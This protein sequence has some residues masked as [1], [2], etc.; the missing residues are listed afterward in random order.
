MASLP[1]GISP[2]PT[3]GTGPSANGNKGADDIGRQ[4]EALKKELRQVKQ[5][6]TL[7]E[8]KRKKQIEALEKQIRELEQRRMQE[9]RKQ[10]EEQEPDKEETPVQDGHFFKEYA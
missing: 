9:R 3:G 10:P 7:P 8:E 2:L 4:I 1:Q 6:K 5:D